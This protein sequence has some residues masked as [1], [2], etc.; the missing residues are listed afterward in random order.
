MYPVYLYVSNLKQFNELR[1]VTKLCHSSICLTAYLWETP[2]KGQEIITGYSL[3]KKN[4]WRDLLYNTFLLLFYFTFITMNFA[5]RYILRFYVTFFQY[6]IRY[7][8]WMIQLSGARKAT[9]R[10]RRGQ[11]VT[12]RIQ[13]WINDRISILTYI[14]ESHCTSFI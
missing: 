14:T 2:E 12:S 1:P 6:R 4:R 5:T 10:D 11:M 8:D 13:H 7:P 9:C 3:K